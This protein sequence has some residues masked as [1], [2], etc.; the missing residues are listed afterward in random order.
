MKAGP[1][2]WVNQKN[3]WVDIVFILKNDNA[4]LSLQLGGRDK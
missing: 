1:K 2:A 3:R 4:F